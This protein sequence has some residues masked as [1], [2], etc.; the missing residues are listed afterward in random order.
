MYVPGLQPGASTDWFDAPVEAQRAFTAAYNRIRNKFL[1]DRGV[2]I[3]SIWLRMRYLWDSTV[4]WNTFP[5]RLY[6]GNIENGAAC[7]SGY[8]PMGSTP[9]FFIYSTTSYRWKL[10]RIF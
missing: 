9:L 10:T 4:A 5:S 8:L 6:Y 7:I 2:G 1:Y 3:P